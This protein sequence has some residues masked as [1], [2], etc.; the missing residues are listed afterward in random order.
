MA[1]QSTELRL[2]QVEQAVLGLRQEQKNHLLVIQD[3]QKRQGESQLQAAAIDARFANVEAALK[4]IA[5]A[6]KAQPQE[7][8]EA[9]P[10]VVKEVKLSEEPISLPSKIKIWQN[11][12]GLNKVSRKG[13]VSF[14]A[15]KQDYQRLHEQFKLPD[16]IE[17]ELIM[18]SFE[19]AALKVANQVM[20]EFPDFNVS[21]L[22]EQLEARLYNDSQRRAQTSSFLQLQWN[23]KRDTLGYFAETVHSQGLSMGVD[24]DLIRATFIKG[25]PLRL[26]T[27]AYGIN[28]TY[29]DVVSA[30][31][32]IAGTLGRNNRNQEQVR[33]V[34]E[35]VLREKDT[36]GTETRS[37]GRSHGITDWKRNRRC[38]ACGELGHIAKDP[39]C[40]GKRKN[41]YNVEGVSLTQG[42]ASGSPQEN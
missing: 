28:G 26:Q 23:E 25:L 42:N 21:A 36:D 12:M 30:I 10:A 19:K 9:S 18:Q 33:V 8:E 41:D 22:W 14:P 32:N 40:K 6:V 24:K 39:Q 38:Y 29:D 1:E 13:D 3:I 4:Q 37:S 34:Q 5:D 2:M 35:T 15:A 7:R 16:H 31:A 27:F 20:R 11:T 17:K